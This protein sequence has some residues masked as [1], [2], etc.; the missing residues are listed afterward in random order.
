MKY[1]IRLLTLAADTLL[2]TT[3]K[4]LH[5]RILEN[6]RRH[7][8][9]EVSGRYHEIFLPE[10][11]VE[12]PFYRVATPVGI[13]DLDGETAVKGFYQS[14]IDSGTT[15][16]LLEEE[17]II[18]SDWGFASE[19]LYKIFMTAEAATAAGHVVDDP[20]GKYIESR[21]ICMMWPYDEK[22]KMIGERVYP[23]A[24]CTIEKC[25]EEDFISLEKARAV[26]DPLIAESRLTEV[27]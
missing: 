13:M 12:K 3:T 23:A 21:M 25:A 18:V 14:L 20:K 9:L 15:V 8:M 5:R 2:K 11:T 22:G 4:P 26:F 17:N 19:A 1:D 24:T 27:A 7:A 6:Y 10:M 16:M